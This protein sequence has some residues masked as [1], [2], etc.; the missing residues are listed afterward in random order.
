MIEGRTVLAVVPA[1]GGSKGIV[2]KNLR[3]VCGISLIGIVGRVVQQL[4]W[5]DLAVVSTDDEQ[6]ARAA[7]AEGLSAPFRRPESLSGDRIGDWEV[8]H[9]ALKEAEERVGGEFAI[10]LMLQ[11]TSP[12]R[13][14][15]QV[16]DCVRMTISGDFDAVW[17]VSETDSKAHPLKQLLVGQDGTMKYYD[18]EGGK[19]IA[20]QQLSPV[21][22]RN[23]VAYSITREC[24]MDQ[25]SIKGARTGALVIEE[26]VANIDMEEDLRAAEVLAAGLRYPWLKSG[27]SICKG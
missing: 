5:I 24:I 27:H 7:E 11:P 19:I 16:E 20:R 26:P 15:K 9:H 21:F 13:T 12:L 22:H 23:G 1:R 3:E 10:V 25:R 6:I 14:P 18:P 17:T 2:K 4:P 8:L